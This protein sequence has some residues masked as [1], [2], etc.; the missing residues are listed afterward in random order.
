MLDRGEKLE[1]AFELLEEDDVSANLSE[2][3][4]TSVDHSWL[5]VRRLFVAF[6]I[7][8]KLH[9]LQ[10]CF[11]ACDVSNTSRAA[12]CFRP[13]ADINVA[14]LPRAQAFSF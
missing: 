8:R 13:I 14:A 5:G 4:V 11:D 10:V 2:S 6:L 1:N 3:L 9:G 7:R 12:F